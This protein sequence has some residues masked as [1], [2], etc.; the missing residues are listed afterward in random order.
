MS[1]T[2]RFDARSVRDTLLKRG[3]PNAERLY[4]LFAYRPFDSR[5]LYWEAETA[6]YCVR[7]VLATRLQASRIRRAI[8]GCLPFL[9]SEQMQPK[10]RRMVAATSHCLTSVA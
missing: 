8:Y 1:D 7:K 6:D 10:R 3:G 2:G 9:V 4:S 5:W